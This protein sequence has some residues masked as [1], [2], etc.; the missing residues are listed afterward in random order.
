M[1]I[2]IKTKKPTSN[3][4]EL[5]IYRILDFIYLNHIHSSEDTI[6]AKNQN[7]YRKAQF[8]VVQFLRRALAAICYPPHDFCCKTLFL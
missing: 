3:G 1:F 2:I 5:P 4:V 7:G 8:N 6:L